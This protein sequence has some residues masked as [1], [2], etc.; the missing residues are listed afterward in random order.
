ML[1]FTPVRRGTVVA[2]RQ[3]LGYN[4]RRSAKNQV[5][6]PYIISKCVCGTKHPPT[7]RNFAKRCS[8]DTVDLTAG[9]CGACIRP[10]R[11]GCR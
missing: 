7:F 8:H 5:L 10:T 2:L 9:T 4:A 11:G 6:S 3:L 1:N